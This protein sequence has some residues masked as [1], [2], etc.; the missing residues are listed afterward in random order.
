MDVKKR[1]YV[2]CHLPGGSRMVRVKVYEKQLKGLSRE[3][4]YL[5]PILDLRVRKKLKLGE[6]PVLF[7][8]I[9]LQS[10]RAVRFTEQIVEIDLTDIPD[11]PLEVP[12]PVSL[13]K[14]FWA[15]TVA[16]VSRLKRALPSTNGA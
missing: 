5:W 9:I 14:L 16:V 1:V 2:R 6:F 13:W 8:N 10:P 11:V 4:S 7:G 3:D 12:A 15:A